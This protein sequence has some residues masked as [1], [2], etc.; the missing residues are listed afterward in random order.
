MMKDNYGIIAL[1]NTHTENPTQNSEKP[2]SVIITAKYIMIKENIF[3][4]YQVGLTLE[5]Q[6]RLFTPLTE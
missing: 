6:S 4:T 1:M 2:N 5:N 3:Q